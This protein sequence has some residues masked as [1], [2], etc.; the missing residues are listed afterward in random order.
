MCLRDPIELGMLRAKAAFTAVRGQLSEDGLATLNNTASLNKDVVVKAFVDAHG[1]SSKTH[2]DLR[3]SVGK[4]AHTRGEEQATRQSAEEIVT[5]KKQLEEANRKLE[6][7]KVATRAA[8][9]E[10]LG[11][12]RKSKQDEE[13]LNSLKNNA[14]KPL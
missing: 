9:K 1:D 6:S 10:T 7:Q 14:T 3:S 12:K 5:L 2:Q 8:A 13:L 11:D 4:P